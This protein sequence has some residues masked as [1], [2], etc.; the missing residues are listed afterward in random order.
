[1]LARRC[2]PS[3]FV[4]H[5]TNQILQIHHA[6][7][8]PLS[9]IKFPVSPLAI[10]RQHYP[11]NTKTSTRNTF[12]SS[13]INPQNMPVSRLARWLAFDVVDIEYC[14]FDTGGREFVFVYFI[15]DESLFAKDEGFEVEFCLGVDS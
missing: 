15:D 3:L 8:V 12:P 9:H 14:F 4:R 5:I 2:S 6:N 11:S 10:V 7:H 1:M 13:H